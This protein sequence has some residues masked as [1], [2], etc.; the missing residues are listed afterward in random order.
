MPKASTP[1][2][3]PESDVPKRDRHGDRSVPPL[4]EFDFDQ[5]GD[6]TLLSEC[7]VGA[8]LRVARSTL[9]AWRA[10][11]DHPLRWLALP[12]GFIRYTAFAVRQFLASGKPRKRGRPRKHEP[13][14][15]DAKPQ[16]AA[17]ALRRR[18]R[19]SRADDAAVPEAS[20]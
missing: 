11:P 18:A 12:N 20:P 6:G 4:P 15:P 3:D 1:V 13:S 2:K 7:E 8:I 17:P 5:L 14:P 10:Q 9:G 16:D 19:R